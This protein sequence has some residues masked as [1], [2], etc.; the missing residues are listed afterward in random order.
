M[1]IIPGRVK[2]D[3]KFKNH[4]KS[5]VLFLDLG[6]KYASVDG[7]GEEKGVPELYLGF[8]KDSLYPDKRVRKN[9][10]TCVQFPEM[11]GWRLAGATVS[12]W[13]VMVGF[14]K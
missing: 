6:T 4:T 5:C 8:D 9:M 14:V 10:S 1:R 3:A 13:T 11:R 12:K 7:Y 2:V